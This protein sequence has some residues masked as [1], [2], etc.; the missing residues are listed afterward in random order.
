MES[1]FLEV[2]G[3]ILNKECSE[4]VLREDVQLKNI[5]I[6]SIQFVHLAVEIEEQF[7][8]EFDDDMLVNTKFVLVKDL[9]D[10]VKSKVEERK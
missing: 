5:G 1:K 9:F 6:K 4:D 8:I 2:I 10:Y 3:K 7:D